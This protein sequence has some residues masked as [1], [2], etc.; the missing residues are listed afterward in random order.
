MIYIY[1]IILNVCVYIYIYILYIYYIILYYIVLYY[2]ILYYII[3]YVCIYILCLWSGFHV[4][5]KPLR[6]CYTPTYNWGAFLLWLRI[7]HEKQKGV[8]RFKK[9]VALNKMWV[10]KMAKNL[11]SLKIIDPHTLLIM[12][13]TK[14]EPPH[15]QTHPN[16]PKSITERLNHVFFDDKFPFFVALLVRWFLPHVE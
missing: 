8:V 3:L 2:I 7:I 12:F 15:V 13:L 9:G 11:V 1:I 10:L 6:W 5:V 14:I 4:Y 16:H